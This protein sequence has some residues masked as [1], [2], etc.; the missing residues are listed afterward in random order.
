MPHA[1]EIVLPEPIET[2]VDER[3]ASRTAE[4]F[5]SLVADLASIWEGE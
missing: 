5:E 4:R 1:T 2:Q 3:I